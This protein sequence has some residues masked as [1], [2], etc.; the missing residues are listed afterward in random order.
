M[1]NLALGSGHRKARSAVVWR[2]DEQIAT[3]SG[4]MPEGMT[5]VV[6]E[7]TLSMPSGCAHWPGRRHGVLRAIPCRVT[8]VGA[9]APHRAAAGTEPSEPAT[10]SNCKSANHTES[11]RRLVLAGPYWRLIDVHAWTL[12]DNPGPALPAK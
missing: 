4:G 3:D 6:L 9:D 10:V 2:D 8:S 11:Q 7:P 5:P 12:R 1:R